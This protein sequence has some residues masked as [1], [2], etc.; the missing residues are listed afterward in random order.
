MRWS[1][2]LVFTSIFSY[3]GAII[4]TLLGYPPLSNIDVLIQIIFYLLCV[5]SLY[6][7]LEFV[8]IRHYLAAGYG[9]GA[10]LNFSGVMVWMNYDG[11]LALGPYMALW[12]I[13]LAIALLD[14][15]KK[16]D[17]SQFLNYQNEIKKELLGIRNLGTMIGNTAY[18][19]KQKKDDIQ[20][21]DILNHSSKEIVN[22]VD[23]LNKYQQYELT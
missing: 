3:I 15:Q 5:F 18:L 1:E 4:I 22:I 17:D 21:F 11:N 7:S 10:I 13:G 14:D 19:I 2:A 8:K 9:L 16:D 23:K 6:S 20:L 12:D